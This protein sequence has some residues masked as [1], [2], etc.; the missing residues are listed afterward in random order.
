MRLFAERP[1]PFPAVFSRYDL[2]Q[3]DRLLG[4]C[5][6]WDIC[7]LTAHGRVSKDGERYRLQ[8]IGRNPKVVAQ[9]PFDVW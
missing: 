1:E 2:S 7:R 6:R 9:A 8:G 5:S 3:E 4:A